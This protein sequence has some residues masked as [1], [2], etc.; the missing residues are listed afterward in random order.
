M[1]PARA[2]CS[3][4]RRCKCTCSVVHTSA[5][6]ELAIVFCMFCLRDQTSKYLC[7]GCHSVARLF[8]ALMSA[9]ASATTVPVI[10]YPRSWLLV[11]VTSRWAVSGASEERRSPSRDM[12]H[13]GAALCI[14][15]LTC[16][17]LTLTHSSQSWKQTGGG[18]EQLVLAL[19]VHVSK[20]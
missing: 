4:H 5:P 2:C 13:S 20:N 6:D 9:R 14:K 8:S 7:Y 10:L 18:C 1:A 15:T 19:H 11:V 17:T 16:D 12:T 3:V